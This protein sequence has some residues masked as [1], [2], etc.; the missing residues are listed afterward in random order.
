MRLVLTVFFLFYAAW[1]SGSRSSS[2]RTDSWNMWTICMT[3]TS[4]WTSGRAWPA[5]SSLRIGESGTRGTKDRTGAPGVRCGAWW[6]ADPFRSS[7]GDGKCLWGWSSADWRPLVPSQM[8][9][10]ICSILNQ[11]V[12]SGS[13]LAPKKAL[14]V[15][16]RSSHKKNS[17]CKAF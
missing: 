10:Y 14:L 4:P 6:A 7:W 17:L 9:C 11:I 5:G 13:S 1:A 3:T 15:F 2:W 16:L 12:L 8:Q